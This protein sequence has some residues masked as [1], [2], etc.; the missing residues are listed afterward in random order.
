MTARNWASWCNGDVWTIERGVDFTIPARRMQQ[1]AHGY[2]ATHDLKVQ[3]SVVDDETLV[4]QFRP[5][6]EEAAI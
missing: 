1:Y 5:A 4:M 6:V 3:T 2:A